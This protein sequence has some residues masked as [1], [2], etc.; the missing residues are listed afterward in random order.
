VSSTYFEYPSFL[1][2]EVLYIQF[3][4]IEFVDQYKQSGR[5]GKMCLILSSYLDILILRNKV[6]NIIRKHT[7]NIN[8]LLICILL[9][10]HSFIFFKFNFFNVYMVVL[11]FNTV[12][13]VFL[14]LCLCILIVCLCIFIV[15]ADTLRLPWLRYSRPFPS[16][17]SQMPGNNSPRRGTARTPPNKWIAFFYV[18]FLCRSVYCLFVN[19]YCTVCV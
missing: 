15:P 13:Y 9:L 10:S 7:D 12:N 11:I 2:R 4:G 14:L 8:W 3:Y 17:V 1:P 18:L 6:S 5:W 19:V 16:V